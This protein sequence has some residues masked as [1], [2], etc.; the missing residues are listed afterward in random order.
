MVRRDRLARQ[1]AGGQTSVPQAALE[2]PARA[3]PSGVFISK[4]RNFPTQ[5]PDFDFATFY[6]ELDEHFGSAEMMLEPQGKDCVFSD[7][8]Y[9]AW[10]RLQQKKEKEVPQI[11]ESTSLLQGLIKQMKKRY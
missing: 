4:Y 5:V 7:E 2:D 11:A 3:C 10:L 1:T 9:S 6:D 8:H